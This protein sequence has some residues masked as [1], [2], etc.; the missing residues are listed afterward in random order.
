M[1]WTKKKK[2]LSY[3]LNNLMGLKHEE[4]IFIF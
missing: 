2:H 4:T 1:Y 3:S